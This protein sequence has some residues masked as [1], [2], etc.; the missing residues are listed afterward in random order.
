V[1]TRTFPAVRALHA[2]VAAV[3]ERHGALLLRIARQY[4]L[5]PTTPQ[6][7]YQRALEIYLRRVESL[8]PVTEVP[9]L[10]VVVIRTFVLRLP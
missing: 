10:K 1:A 3:V 2:R 8:D 9:W 6:D 5:A 4:S 7:A